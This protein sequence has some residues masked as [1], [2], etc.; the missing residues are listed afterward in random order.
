MGDGGD[1]EL[2]LEHLGD[3]TLNRVWN[4]GNCVAFRADF[5]SSIITVPLYQCCAFSLL[6]MSIYPSSSCSCLGPVTN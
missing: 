2:E 5:S 1:M 4:G 3:S 6:S